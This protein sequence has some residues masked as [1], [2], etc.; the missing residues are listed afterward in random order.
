MFAM[1][2]AVT[3]CGTTQRSHHGHTYSTTDD[4][5][6]D[7]VMRAARAG[8][9]AAY[10]T[11]PNYGD[12]GISRIKAAPPISLPPPVPGLPNFPRR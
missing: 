12:Y 1:T 2:M 5:S 8:A 7:S 4:G 6:T 9:R 11:Q 10:K 3:A